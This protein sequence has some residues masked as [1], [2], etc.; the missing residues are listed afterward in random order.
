MLLQGTQVFINIFESEVGTMTAGER[1]GPS[2]ISSSICRKS[3][4]REL[5][6]A[7]CANGLWWKVFHRNNWMPLGVDNRRN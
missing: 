6:R 7:A 5:G 1:G 3:D 4:E 2:Y